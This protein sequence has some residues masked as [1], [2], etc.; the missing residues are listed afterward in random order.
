M[1]IQNGQQS[2][3]EMDTSIDEEMT[4]SEQNGKSA[5]CVHYMRGRAGHLFL[6]AK[7]REI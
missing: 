1:I 5:V 7:T 4:E 6:N 3:S 2:A